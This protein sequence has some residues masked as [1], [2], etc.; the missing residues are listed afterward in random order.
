MSQNRRKM[1]KMLQNDW[2]QLYT[3]IRKT[4]SSCFCLTDQ[5]QSRREYCQSSGS[6]VI[7]QPKKSIIYACSYLLLVKIKYTKYMR[8]ESV[9]M[10]FCAKLQIYILVKSQFKPKSKDFLLSNVFNTSTDRK[11]FL[12]ISVYRGGFA[13][14]CYILFC[15]F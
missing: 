14:T 7:D 15:K 10:S 9:Y 2:G 1:A 4:F 13:K 12:S 11:K 5:S 8:S 3:D 6:S